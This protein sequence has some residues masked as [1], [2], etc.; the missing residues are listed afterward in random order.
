MLNVI[1]DIDSTLVDTRNSPLPQSLNVYKQISSAGMPS[2]YVY[3]RPHLDSFLNWLFSNF[4]V[5][6]WTAG[7]EPYANWIAT[8]VV[9]T[10]RGKSLKHVLSARDCQASYNLYGTPKSLKYLNGVD[11][12][13][14]QKNS[15]L[16]DDTNANCVNQK[17]NCILVAPFYATNDADNELSALPNKITS[18]FYSLAHRP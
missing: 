1:L 6:L 9:G 11:P 12:S 17:N 8:Y 15:L 13:I 10:R 7:S 5:S 4:S 2:L 18:Q 3:K 16:V 14:S